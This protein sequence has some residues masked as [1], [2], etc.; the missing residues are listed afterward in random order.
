MAQRAHLLADPSAPDAFAQVSAFAS[1]HVGV[2]TVITLM[3]AYY[4]WRRLSAVMVVY[5]AGTV[6]ATVHLGWHFFVD[7]IAGVLIALLAV[8]L[9]HLTIF[10]RE[11]LPRRRTAGTPA[12][13]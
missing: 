8:G 12:R 11:P 2:A 4:G 5:V 13:S 6:V 7:D 1:L 9:G 10:P 3:L